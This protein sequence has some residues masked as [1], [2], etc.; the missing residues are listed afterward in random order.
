MNGK[1]YDLK[2]DYVVNATGPWVDELDSFDVKETKSKLHITKGVHLVVDEKRLPVKQSVYFDTPDKRMIFIIPREGKSYIGTTDTFYTGDLSA[3]IVTAED[4][5]YILNCVNNYF[6]ECNVTAKDVESCWAGL[7]PLVNKPGK[8]PS[9]ISRKDEMFESASGLITIAGG[10]LTGYRK[11]AQRVVGLIAKRYL[12]D[13][14]KTL[15]QCSTAKILLSGGISGGADNFKRF[16]K[17]KIA[18]GVSLG[19]S[20]MEA[21]LLTHR[22]GTN[23]EKLFSIISTIKNEEKSIL[24]LWLHA[25][26]LY[27][28]EEEMC[29]SPADFF[30]RRTGM[31][32]FDIASVMKWKDTVLNYMQN[33]MGWDD[34][35]KTKYEDEMNYL[36]KEAKLLK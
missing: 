5:N 4:R 9:E 3:P 26:L 34:L 25:Q 17:S 19:L 13:H 6:P 33:I 29:T 7:R 27:A 8:G 15:P 21:E 22:Y 24:P 28:I 36:I 12:D 18:Q 1:E 31:L 10:K 30:I 2:A 14:Q 16:T 23:I 35:L 11:M 32:Y 20:T